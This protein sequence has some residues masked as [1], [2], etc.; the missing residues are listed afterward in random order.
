MITHTQ[1]RVY[2]ISHTGLLHSARPTT[3]PAAATTAHHP[4]HSGSDR[5]DRMI[6]PAASRKLARAS[7]ALAKPR[8]P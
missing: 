8:L 5:D 4:S 6:Q 2:G 7:P 3:N 1:K